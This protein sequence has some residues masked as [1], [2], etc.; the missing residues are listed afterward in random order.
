M[1]IYTKAQAK[2]RITEA[3]ANTSRAMDA[4]W[5]AL[6]CLGRAWVYVQ[7]RLEGAQGGCSECDAAM[8]DAHEALSEAKHRF[9]DAFFEVMDAIEA[10]DKTEAATGPRPAEPAE[11]V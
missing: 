9:I 4:E 5:D 10:E 7:T 6:D 8:N 11:E 2:G 3:Q 1:T